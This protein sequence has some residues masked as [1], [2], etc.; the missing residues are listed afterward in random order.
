V[1]VAPSR[2]AGSDLFVEVRI[3]P[4]E[5]VIRLGGR[6]LTDEAFR[7]LWMA[8]EKITGSGSPTRCRPVTCCLLCHDAK[9]SGAS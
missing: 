4:G 3:A 9:N 1:N 5:I 7:L 6:V 2:I 8:D